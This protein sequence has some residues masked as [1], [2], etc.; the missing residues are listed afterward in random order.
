MLSLHSKSGKST[1][2]VAI[3]CFYKDF[4][5]AQSWHKCMYTTI[6]AAYCFTWGWGGSEQAYFSLAFM[7]YCLFI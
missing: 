1:S 6:L 2:E 3:R 5:V 7:L 4:I